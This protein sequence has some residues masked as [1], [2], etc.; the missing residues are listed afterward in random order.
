MYNTMAK[1]LATFNTII[2]LNFTNTQINRI[3]SLDNRA[4]Q[5]TKNDNI[6]FTY[7]SILR[8]ACQKTLSENASMETLATTYRI[9]S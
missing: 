1:P 6:P 7:D 4:K 3:N 8:H 5:K 9:I 2:K